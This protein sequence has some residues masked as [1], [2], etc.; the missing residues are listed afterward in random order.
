MKRHKLTL[1]SPKVIE[2]LQV[3]EIKRCLKG[4]KVTLKLAE[5]KD[6]NLDE[7][8][9]GVLN[10]VNLLYNHFFYLNFNREI[11]RCLKRHKFVLSRGKE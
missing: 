11:R 4:H 2:L 7:K 8:S 3:E 5:V 6:L 10:N 1:Q 9:G